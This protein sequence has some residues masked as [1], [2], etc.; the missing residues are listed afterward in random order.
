M[1]SYRWIGQDLVLKK[2][3]LMRAIVYLCH[4]KLRKREFIEFFVSSALQHNEWILLLFSL[5]S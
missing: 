5:D 4:L 2:V 3:I 1:S